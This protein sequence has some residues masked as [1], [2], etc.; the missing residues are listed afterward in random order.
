MQ[1]QKNVN[2]RDYVE[3][4]AQL[5]IRRGIIYSNMSAK[6]DMLK[7]RILPDMVG[8]AEED[9]P[10]YACYNP[11][12]MIKGVAEKETRDINIATQ[13]WVICTSDFLVGWVL[14]EANQQYDV[15]EDKVDDPWGFNTFKTHLLRAHLNTKSAEY[16][17]LKVLFSN[18]KFVSTYT[19]A[20]IGTNS[21]PANAVGLDIV[22]VR[23][24]E[25]YILLQSGTTLALTQDTLYMRV[26]SPKDV[27]NSTHSYIKMTAGS[28]EIVAD[29]IS[30]HGK[31]AT[32]LGK[33][34]MKVAGMLGAPTSVDGSPLVPLTDIT[35]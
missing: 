6:S 16:S 10:N 18:A 12:M 28:I 35:C 34:G 23:T 21:T 19:E 31:K 17:E 3:K 29:N 11:T 1:Q 26:G 15:E 25:R 7:V 32:S 9:L 13:V 22:N 8:Y 14:G 2:L 30:I 5:Q 4:N 24:G 27:N 20:D 33:H